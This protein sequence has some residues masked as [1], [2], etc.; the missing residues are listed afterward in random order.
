LTLA[1]TPDHWLVVADE[2]RLG[3]CLIKDL[4]L[5]M[6]QIENSKATIAVKAVASAIREDRHLESLTL[7]I[8]DGFTDEAGVAL[9]VAL[10]INKTL[11]MLVLDDN[12]F[13]IRDSVLTK[14]SLGAQAYEAFGAMLRVNTSIN[15]YLP[16]FNFYV[17][18]NDDDDQ[19][20]VDSRNQMLIE[21]RLNKFG[22]GRLLMSSQTP[23][24][25][26]V[27]ALQELNART[28]NDLFKVSCLYSLLRLNP[29]VVD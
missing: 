5:C 27:N 8:E 25:E 3:R 15:V 1:L 9:A 6:E 10:T 24:E 11:R 13:S 16:T 20:L 12:L 2:I 19:K 7:Q 26:W 23:R 17:D 14:D 18:D 29:S 28:D 4:K 21:V 22:R